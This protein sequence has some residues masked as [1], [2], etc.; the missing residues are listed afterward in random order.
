M[1]AAGVVLDVV[2]AVVFATHLADRLTSV[3]KHIVPTKYRT[4]TR[5]SL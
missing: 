4:S 2:F 1:I 5:G 3:N